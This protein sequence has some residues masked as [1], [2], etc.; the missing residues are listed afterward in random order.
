VSSAVNSWGVSFILNQDGTCAQQSR[1]WQDSEGNQHK[2]V[3]IVA[4]EIL[5]LSDS[6]NDV[7]SSESEAEDETYPF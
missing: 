3:E 7:G 6:K 1:K 5:L 4:R 2:S